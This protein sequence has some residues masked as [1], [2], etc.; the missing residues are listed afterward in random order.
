LLL[1]YPIAS[2]QIRGNPPSAEA[3]H[4]LACELQQLVHR[5]EPDRIGGAR[6]RARRLHPVLQTVVA[7]RALV[8]LPVALAIHIHHA[9]GTR[10]HAVAAA[11]AD[12]LLHVHTVELRADDGTSGAR[13]E[14]RRIAAVLA[15]VRHED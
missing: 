8:R 11:V 10:R 15:H 13:L 6:L 14:A 2:V 9:E 3:G 12:I 5:T 4:A 7:E 1:E